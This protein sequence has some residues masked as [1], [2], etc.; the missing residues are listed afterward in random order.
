MNISK[1]VILYCAFVILL[2]TRC[3]YILHGIENNVWSIGFLGLSESDKLVID[4]PQEHP[5]ASFWLSKIAL[6]H[7]DITQAHKMLIPFDEAENPFIIHHMGKVL[8]IKGDLASAIQMW[9]TIGDKESIYQAAKRAENENRLKDALLIYRE[10]YIIDPE[11]MSLELASFILR[12]PEVDYNEV[13]NILKHAL[14]TY[15]HSH[16]RVSW[17]R[18]LG[19]TLRRQNEWFEAKNA[20]K[21]ALSIKPDD[22]LSLVRYSLSYYMNGGSA[23]QAI[24]YLERAIRNNPGEPHAFSTKGLIMLREGRYSESE[25]WYLLA[26]ERNPSYA[27][28]IYL[29]R[30]RAALLDNN[31]PLAISI[32]QESIRQYPDFTR[33]YFRLANAYYL[34]GN[35][36]DAIVVI[37]KIL[38][39]RDETQIGDL[40]L[41]AKIYESGGENRNALEIYNYILDIDPGNGN[42]IIGR[43]RI[44]GR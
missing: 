26:L 44:N 2:S 17:F 38:T 24:V 11:E 13:E 29:G 42:A 22:Y 19:D 18:T 36:Q 30:G 32:Y 8:E 3:Q 40:L 28:F 37:D 5:R 21:Q 15:P 34:N 35:L 20:Y 27:Q 16:H 14:S 4:P 33:A 39:M 23:E 1:Q 10:L 25:K 31:I 12:T 6:E 9:K 41:A 7:G 43:E